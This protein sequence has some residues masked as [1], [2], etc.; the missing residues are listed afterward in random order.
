MQGTG[1]V[2]AAATGGLP[3]ST[4]GTIPAAG[5]GLTGTGGALGTGG[6]TSPVF[7]W[8]DTYNPNG[9]VAVTHQQGHY[10]GGA[11]GQ[12]HAPGGVAT[13]LALGGTVFAADGV[14]PAANVQVGIASGGTVMT[15]Y[16][17]SAGN[18]FVT[19]SATV[20]W[21]TADIAIRKDVGEVIMA[22]NP[23]ARG[24]CNGCH[25]SSNRIVVP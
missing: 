2:G 21:A 20:D 9:G 22:A 25:N 23:G 3:R 17:G 14:T 5:G 7:P 18:F 1:G 12:C 11:C 10:E 24:D 15:A 6:A 19:G 16:S 8:P 13:E 4:G